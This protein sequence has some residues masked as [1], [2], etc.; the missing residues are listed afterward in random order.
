MGG[1]G[2]GNECGLPAPSLKVTS[3]LAS[4]QAEKSVAGHGILT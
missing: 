1:G 3:T 2:V 4:S